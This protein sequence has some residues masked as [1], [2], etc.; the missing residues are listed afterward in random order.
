MDKTI[1]FIS[2]LGAPFGG[3]DELWT[4]TAAR[5]AKLGVSVAASVHGSP[6][7]DRRVSELARVGVDLRPRPIKPSFVALVRRYL[8][9][10]S[11]ITLDVE[12]TFGNLSPS[13]VVISDGSALPPIDLIESCV[14][15]GWRFA[16]VVH[17]NFE[18]WPADEL[19]ARYRKAF[20]LAQRYYFV[21]EANRTLTE[22]QLGHSFSN[23]EIVRNPVIVEVASPIPWPTTAADEELRMACVARLSG[24]KGHDILFEVLSAQR[25]MERKWH[26]N[27]YG[28]GP[29]R[30]VLERLV[31]RHKLDD[32][33]SFAGHA[34]VEGI[35]RENHLLVMPSRYE[36]GPMTTIEAMYC[37]RPVVATSVG[38]NPEVIK[39]GVTGFLAGAAVADSLGGALERMWGQ[40]DRLEEMG[41]LAGASIREFMPADPVGIF[42]KKLVDMAGL[43]TG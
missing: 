5:L 38:S 1:L 8:S 43:S 27:L 34:P 18:Q 33:V 14:A 20:S 16:I 17:N 30:D 2:T 12:R 41:K 9:G 40:R 29:I 21:S 28:K 13:L 19:A 25:W 4:R 22:K 37:E 36:G 6:Q 31:K 11:Q 3:C 24:E 23:A 42:A 15:R 35:W 26:L 39:D 7:L 32:R 10:K